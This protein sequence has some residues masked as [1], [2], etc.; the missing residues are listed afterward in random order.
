CSLF[1]C[2][3][4]FIFGT[5]WVNEE[6]ML[7]YAHTLFPVA[8]TPLLSPA[9]QPYARVCVCVCVCVCMCVQHTPMPVCVCVYAAQP[10]AGVCVCV[11]QKPARRTIFT[12]FYFPMLSKIVI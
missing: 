8:P 12:N 2:Q 3:S 11:C 10:Y 9:A 7:K 6:M 1:S 5:L 4:R